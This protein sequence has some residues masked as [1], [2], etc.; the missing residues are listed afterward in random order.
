MNREER[1][2]SLKNDERLVVSAIIVEF[3]DGRT[4]NLDTQKVMIIDKETKAQL[5]QEVIEQTKE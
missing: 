5:F 3:E 1:R 2:K 4:V